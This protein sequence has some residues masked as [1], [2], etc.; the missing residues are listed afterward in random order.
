MGFFRKRAK[1]KNRPVVDDDLY[2]EEEHDVVIA[3]HS[4][5]DNR[6]HHRFRDR[7][8]HED[9]Y[10]EAEIQELSPEPEPRDDGSVGETLATEDHFDLHIPVKPRRGILRNRREQGSSL[11]PPGHHSSKHWNEADSVSS[12]S[13]DSQLLADFE[14]DKRSRHRENQ[15]ISMRSIKSRQSQQRHAKHASNNRPDPTLSPEEIAGPIGGNIQRQPPYQQQ[16]KEH[17]AT[18]ARCCFF[19]ESNERI[20]IETRIPSN[21][22]PPAISTNARTSNTVRGFRTPKLEEDSFMNSTIPTFATEYDVALKSG[23]TGKDVKEI[24]VQNDLHSTVKKMERIGMV[25]CFGISVDQ[26]LKTL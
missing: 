19:E 21:N 10:R 8:H 26:D 9:D 20:D 6:H 17:D 16:A 25:L 24:S 14:D 3:R 7:Y 4:S 5:K 1:A 2:Y 11:L 12:I 13:C 18:Y 23:D 15:T 22:D